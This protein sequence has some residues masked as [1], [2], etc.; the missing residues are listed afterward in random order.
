MLDL[1]FLCVLVSGF[2]DFLDGMSARVLRVTSNIGKE[3]DSLAD[4][5]SFGFLP[6]VVMFQLLKDQSNDQF[7]P[8]F[9]F[10]IACFSALRLA[11]FNID[12][13]QSDQFVGLNTPA[14]TILITSFFFWKEANFLNSESWLFTQQG[15]LSTVLISALMLVSP[16]KF[17]SFKF[18]STSLSKNRSR[19]ILILCSI[20]LLILLKELAFPIIILCYIVVSLPLNTKKA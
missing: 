11:K 12:E 13:N 8:Y 9:A 18:S 14:N 2:F 17:I 7:T 5:I 16:L 3:L 10:I 6:S 20:G 1:V 19:Y 4:M 15:L